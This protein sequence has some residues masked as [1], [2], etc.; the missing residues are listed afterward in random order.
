MDKFIILE[1]LQ[2]LKMLRSLSHLIITSESIYTLRGE[3]VPRIRL[4]SQDPLR[5]WET[6]REEIH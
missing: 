2:I 6:T 5:N 1:V 3:L 4:L